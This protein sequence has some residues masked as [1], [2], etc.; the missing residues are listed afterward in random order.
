[1]LSLPVAPELRDDTI[2]KVGFFCRKNLYIGDPLYICPS[3]CFSIDEKWKAGLA[4]PDVVVV[5]ALLEQGHK[6][7]QGG[8]SAILFAFIK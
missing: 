6:L 8:T 2:S 1:M 4:S 5:A 7:V 3:V